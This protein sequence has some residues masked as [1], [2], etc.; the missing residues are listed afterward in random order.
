MNTIA[1]IEKLSWI[2]Q[3]AGAVWVF[4]TLLLIVAVFDLAKTQANWVNTR[5]ASIR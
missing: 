4:L 3:V 2:N 5:L 1:I